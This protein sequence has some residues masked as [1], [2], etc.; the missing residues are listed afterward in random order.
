MT[1]KL[2]KIDPIVRARPVTTRRYRTRA[3]PL[4]DALNKPI[5]AGFPTTL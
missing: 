1:E 4:Q 5:Q 2:R 3:L